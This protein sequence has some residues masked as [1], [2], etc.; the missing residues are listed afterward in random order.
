METVET[1]ARNSGIAAL[2]VPASLTAKSFYTRLGYNAVREVL[3]GEERTI[4]M[5]KTLS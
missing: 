1:I 2:R 5:E 4:V 3:H